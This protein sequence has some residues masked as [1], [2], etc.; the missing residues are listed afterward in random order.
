[1]RLV[2]IQSPCWSVYTPPYNI[3]L[4]KAVCEKERHG[5]ACLDFNIKFYHYLAKRGERHVYDKP[6]NWYNEE[7]VKEIIRNYSEFIDECVDEVFKFPSRA[8]GF[9]VTGLSRFFSEEIA[10]RIKLRDKEKIIIFGGP[11]C[12][13][14]ELGEQLLFNCPYVDVLCRLEGEKALPS[15]LNIIEK[16]GAPQEFTGIIFRKKDGEIASCSE[17]TA[18]KDLDSLPFADFSDFNLHEYIEKKLPISTSRGCINKCLFCGESGIWKGYRF[19]SSENIYEEIKYQLTR[20]PF[21]ESVFFNDSLLNGSIEAL[22]GLCDLL[23]KNKVNIS[24]GGQAVIREEMSPRLI[25]KMKKAGFSHVS[26]G[27][28]SASP[29]V[30]KMIGK[31][32]VPEL[33]ERVIRDTKKAGVRVDVNIVVGFPTETADDI[34]M[35]AD[36]LKRNRKFI[37]EIFFHPL[38]VS[39]GSSFYEQ[40]DKWGIKF[41]NQFNPITWYSAREG[42]NLSKR[43]KTLEFYKSHIGDKGESFFTLGEYNLFIAE[44]YFSAGD[45]K[46]AYSHYAKAEELNG[47]IFK[48]K[49]IKERMVLSKSKLA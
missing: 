41:E 11:H 31:R 29:R 45:Y 2:L 7:Y 47:D 22:N 28:E 38:V 5:V 19:R 40:R 9:T 49:F 46:N 16:A 48:D 1:M 12:F 8:V 20:Y 36:F 13:E 39:R 14:N 32:F 23:I 4:L 15:F 35:T 17:E 27:L 18:V 34:A 42:N 21:I 26:Y 37:D 43:L 33:A 30:L 25:L 6:T 24:W 10:K 3:A 44:D